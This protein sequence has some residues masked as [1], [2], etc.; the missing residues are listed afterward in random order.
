M[1]IM[2]RFGEAKDADIQFVPAGCTLNNQP[3]DADPDIVHVDTG[4]GRFDHH[5]SAD[6]TLSAA[7]LV[8]REFAPNNEAL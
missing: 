1:W 4:G 2:I 6:H 3:A 5:H 8:R 7:E